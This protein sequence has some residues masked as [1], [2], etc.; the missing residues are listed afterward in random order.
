ML[1][2]ASSRC[3]ISSTE[4]R[5]HEEP[6][7]K[8]YF[9]VKMGVYLEDGIGLSKPRRLLQRNEQLIPLLLHYTT[10]ITSLRLGH[11]HA[12]NR[13]AQMACHWMQAH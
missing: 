3:D 7:Q 8:V 1:Y 9:Q 13:V 12:C 10:T 11:V 6:R 4:F 5:P 2:V